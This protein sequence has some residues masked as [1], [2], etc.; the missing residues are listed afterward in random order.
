MRIFQIFHYNNL[1]KSIL[2]MTKKKL[3][4]YNVYNRKDLAIKISMFVS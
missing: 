1:F 4:M 3:F 2:P